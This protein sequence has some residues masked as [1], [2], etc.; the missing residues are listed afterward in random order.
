V[1]IA[2]LE[3][4][5]ERCHPGAGNR[6]PAPLGHPTT[7]AAGSSGPTPE[8]GTLVGVRTLAGPNTRQAR[9]AFAARITR[10][11]AFAS[12]EAM[13]PRRPTPGPATTTLASGSRDSSKSTPSRAGAPMTTTT[14]PATRS[15]GTTSAAPSAGA[16]G[17]GRSAE[18][19][20]A[21]VR[22]TRAATGTSPLAR[23]R[24]SSRHICF[25]AGEVVRP[26]GPTAGTRRRQPHSGGSPC[27]RHRSTGSD[28][29][30]FQRGGSILDVS[31]EAHLGQ[32]AVI[33][34]G[35]TSQCT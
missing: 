25:E 33:S 19:S 26:S 31:R 29:T 16:A 13:N 23:S 9:V 6:P 17:A 34:I 28:S 11:G 4:V 22:A 20:G 8:P 18:P 24:P 30:S 5:H 3:A 2:P 14:S 10:Q 15:T 21:A 1:S 32:E 27:P 12:V 7:T 35:V